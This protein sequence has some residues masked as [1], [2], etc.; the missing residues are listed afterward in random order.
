MQFE[1]WRIDQQTENIAHEQRK[2]FD[3]YFTGQA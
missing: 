3:K 1:F 2:W